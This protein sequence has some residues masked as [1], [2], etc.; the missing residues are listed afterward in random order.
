MSKTAT[1]TK[2][3]FHGGYVPVRVNFRGPEHVRLVNKGGLYVAEV[4]SAALNEW[5]PQMETTDK[6]KGIEFVESFY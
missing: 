1:A 4:L 5:I 3:A 2:N 6:Q